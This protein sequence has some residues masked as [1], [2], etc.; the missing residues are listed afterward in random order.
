MRY[1]RYKERNGKKN[2]QTYPKLRVLS[3]VT[4]QKSVLMSQKQTT[5][6]LKPNLLTYL[7][8]MLLTYLLTYSME[9]IPS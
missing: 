8:F 4:M 5:L 3:P 2:V 7:I 1:G 9:Q 6:Q